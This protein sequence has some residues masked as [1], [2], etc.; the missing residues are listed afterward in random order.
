[1]VDPAGM[2]ER[3]NFITIALALLVSGQ[4][5][6]LSAASA[7]LLVA[8]MFRYVSAVGLIT[9]VAG[10][11]VASARGTWGVSVTDRCSWHDTTNS[12][13]ASPKSV[14]PASCSRK[15]RD[16]WKRR[17]IGPGWE[18]RPPGRHRTGDVHRPRHGDRFEPR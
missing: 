11:R 3:S 16:G 13:A 9:T 4:V 10:A 17:M 8:L 6:T 2:L 5:Y 1:M 18:N 12:P 14:K 15:A 7:T